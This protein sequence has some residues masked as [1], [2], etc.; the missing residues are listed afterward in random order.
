MTDNKPT[1]FQTQIKR[2]GPWYQSIEMNGI[3]TRKKEISGKRLWNDINNLLPEN[4]KNLRILDL[5]CNAGYHSCQAAIKGAEVVGIDIPTKHGRWQPQAKFV[6]NY[7]EKMHGNLN[8]T[9]IWKDIADVNFNELGRFDYVFALAIL[10]HIGKNKFGKYTPEIFQFQKEVVN[11]IDSDKFI[12]RTRDYKNNNIKF[13][14]D[15]FKDLNFKCKYSDLKA[16]RGLAL[17]EK[18][19]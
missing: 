8:I 5:G 14:N 10:Y 1:D 13:Y 3:K 9:Y 18:N 17:Y 19:S 2:L 16:N 7:F 15:F 12:V 11:R 6:K 4:L